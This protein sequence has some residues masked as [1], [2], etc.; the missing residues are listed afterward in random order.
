M[1]LGSGGNGTCWTGVAGC[2]AVF[3]L[4][5][6]GS[7]G[8]TEAVIYSFQGWSQ[9]DGAFPAYGLIF[10]EAGNLYGVTPQ[11]GSIQGNC[12]FGDGCGTVFE[13]SP[14]GSGGWTETLI[15]V[16]QNDYP[17]EPGGPLTFDR[18]GN[19]YSTMN[20]GGGEGGVV[21]LSPNSGGWELT[22]LYTWAASS[23]P[24][25]VTVDK[26]GNVYGIISGMGCGGGEGFCGAVFELAPNGSGGWTET[27]LYNF[28]GGSDGQGPSSGV[29]FDQRGNLLGTT[30]GGGGTGCSYCGTVFELSPSGP[31]WTKTTL[32][33]FQG[34]SD[35]WWPNSGLIV[36]QAGELY[37]T[38]FPGGG[39]GCDGDDGCGVVY[40]V[41]RESL[42]TFSPTSL[43]FGSQTIGIAG[44]PQVVTLTNNGNEPL[45]ITSIEITGANAGDFSETNNCPSPLPANNSCNISVSFTPTATGARSAAVSVTDN[46][47]GSPQ[48]VPLSGVGV[49]PAVTFSPASLT[50]SNQTVGTKSS[51]QVTTATNTGAGT[52]SITSIA[53]TGSNRSEF[54][55]TNNCPSSLSP[56]DSCEI[57]VTFAP[58]ALGSAAALLSVADNVPGSPQG[59]S[60]TGTADVGDFSLSVTSQASQTVTPGQAANYA[61]AVAPISGFAQ[62]VAL[63]CSGAPAQST[64]TVTPSSVTLD[65]TSS[66]PA[67]VAVVTTAASASLVSPAGFPPAGIRLALWLAFFGLSGVVLLGG[68]PGKRRGSAVYGLLLLCMLCVVM[69]WSACGGGSSSS[70][71]G[72]GTPAGTYTLT[73]TGTYSSG[74]ANL[75]HSTK[76]T[77]VVQ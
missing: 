39:T 60:L 49:L 68:G 5:P 58:T 8:W 33:R 6:N 62:K 18:T 77:L 74:S 10:D 17:A 7:G 14:N 4:S 26:S 63:S 41:F 53:I 47:P 35:G 45:T 66:A 27:N 25:A 16:F 59:V 65:G 64:C 1:K 51:P 72:G 71:S 19:L 57:S 69:M 73:V 9:G 23:Y 37:G 70:G 21:E 29:I 43:S 55:E 75:A 61:I 56:S 76:L 50:F 13:L 31:G 36:D 3:E 32:Y 38:A 22:S 34:G 42:A 2:G 28:Q 44:S 48:S 54:A 52:L 46:A 67:N 40:E 20:D 24:S 30:Y 11:G 15:Y 12:T